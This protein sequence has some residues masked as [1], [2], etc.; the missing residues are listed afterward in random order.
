M[1]NNLELY[2]LKHGYEVFKLAGGK[3]NFNYDPLGN[4]NNSGRV[5]A[6]MN[7]RKW[8]LDGSDAHYKTSTQLLLQKT[9]DEFS[10][11][12][13]RQEQESIEK[14]LMKPSFTCG[15]YQWMRRYAPAREE[16]DAY[17]TITKLLELLITSSLSDMFLWKNGKTLDFDIIKNKKFLV[18]VSFI[19]SNKELATSFSSL[20]FRNLLDEC[21]NNAPAHNIFMYVDEFATLENPFIIKDT[22]EKGRSAK[23]ATT[24]SM[25]DIN[26]IV[27]QTNE[28]YL[29]SLLG[30]INTFIV[31][32]GATRNTAEKLAGVQIADIEI[33]LMNLRKP[34]DG[35]KPTAIYISKYPALNKRITAEVFRFTPYIYDMKAYK[36][37]KKAKIGRAHV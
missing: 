5:E 2:A 8:S 9:V 18:I 12:Y 7:M 21:T 26:Q 4:L 6:I 34:I 24:L 11:I 28:A 37:T 15:Y 29:N 32:S 17:T 10:K 23:I 31:Y 13:R 30:T 36:D 27:I 33:V 3:S 1:V 19:S 14:V 16:S 20:M 35:R 22:I 25:Q